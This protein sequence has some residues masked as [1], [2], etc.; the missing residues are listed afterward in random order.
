MSGSQVPTIADIYLACDILLPLK[1]CKDCMQKIDS[2]YWQ[3]LNRVCTV[4][5]K[6]ITKSCAAAL[7]FSHFVV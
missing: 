6:E 1:V 7:N 4:R 5:L 3:H 2:F